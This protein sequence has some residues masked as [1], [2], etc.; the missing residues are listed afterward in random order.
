MCGQWRRKETYRKEMLPIGRLKEIV[1]EVASFK[2]EIYVWGGEP[3]LYPDIV[4]FITYVKQ[5]KIPLLL[6]TN[7]VLLQKYARE[8]VTLRVDSINISIDGPGEI[9]DKIRGVFGGFN[10]VIQ[11]VTLINQI[12]HDLKRKKPML[13]MICTISE[14]NQLYLEET[15]NVAIKSGLFDV[16][17]FG[18]GWFTTEEI[19]H[20]NNKLFQRL[21]GCES[22]SWKSFVNALGKVDPVKVQKLMQS[23]RRN[24]HK[25]PVVFFP[26]IGSEEVPTYYFKPNIPVGKKMCLSP[27]VDLDIRPNG[28]VTFCPDY[29]DYILGN[30]KRESLLK[31][32]NGDKAR[33]FRKALTEYGLFPICSRC[34]GLYMY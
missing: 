28:D 10:K 18:L 2:P 29:P 32:W 25:V 27:W 23:V 16:L 26:N 30:V 9:N 12:R 15:L 19:G 8:M 4:E 13:K 34:C 33:K 5:K 17:I 3:F 21:F 20:A 11:G 22:T 6:G 24:L 1:D 14:M 7:G 31:V